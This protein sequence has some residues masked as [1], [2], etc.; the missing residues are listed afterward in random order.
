[1]NLQVRRRLLSHRRQLLGRYR[2]E[3]VRADEELE[4]CTIDRSEKANGDRDADL[5]LS[6]GDADVRA[7]AEVVGAIQRIDAGTYGTC[8]ECGTPIAALRLQVLPA[9]A[10]C[11][12][13]A[14]R[15]E[16]SGR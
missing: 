8:I 4:E 13:C 6:L 3:I 16:L 14:T 10:T 7:L 12:P 9:A 15:A 2:N 1:M 5:L 11:L